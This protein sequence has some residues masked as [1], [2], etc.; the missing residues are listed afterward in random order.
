MNNYVDPMDAVLNS[1]YNHAMT[2][3]RRVAGL[4]PYETIVIQP[5]QE[6]NWAEINRINAPGGALR[7]IVEGN[8][9]KIYKRV[10]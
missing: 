3:V 1:A 4:D 9:V 7:A 10:F 5:G 8:M 2:K 6:I